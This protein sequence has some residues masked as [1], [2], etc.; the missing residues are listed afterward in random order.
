MLQSTGLSRRYGLV[1]VNC[2]CTTSTLWRRNNDGETVCNACGLYFKLHGVWV[3]YF[4]YVYV[5]VPRT[6]IRL[7][8]LRPRPIFKFCHASL[9]FLPR[10]AMRKRGLCCR[11]LSGCLSVTLV[12]YVSTPLKISSNF[13]LGRVAASF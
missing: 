12:D 3:R 13:F 5:Y 4:L 2:G 11:P 8:E 1:C 6:Q 9:P 10:G 7:K